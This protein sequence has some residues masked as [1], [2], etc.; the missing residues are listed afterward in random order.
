MH[1]RGACVG[2]GVRGG[3]WRCGGVHG[4]QRACV[5]GGVHGMHA[6]WHI[7]QDTVNEWAVHI[8]LECILV[9]HFVTRVILE[10]KRINSS[11]NTMLFYW[12]MWL[13][14]FPDIIHE[15]LSMNIF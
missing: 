15:Y 9:L 1:G 4:G 3:G 2:E 5:Q 13:T 10:G 6:P 11:Y 12:Q 7:L 8:L 14:T